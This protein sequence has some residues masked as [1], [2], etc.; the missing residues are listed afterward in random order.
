MKKILKESNQHFYRVWTIENDINE[1]LFMNK[2]LQ[3]WIFWNLFT[4]FPYFRIHAPHWT[5]F[6]VIMIIAQ[7]C[8]KTMTMYSRAKFCKN[9]DLNSIFMRNFVQKIIFFFEWMFIFYKNGFV[10][11][12]NWGII[13]CKK[14]HFV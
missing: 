1:F 14:S 3:L 9:Y 2:I 4:S 6:F 11:L 13:S 12:R 7:F 10:L 5:T 8:A